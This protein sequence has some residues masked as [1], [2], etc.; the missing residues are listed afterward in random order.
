MERV[1]FHWTA[2]SNKASATDKEHYHILI[3]GDG[4]LIRG[5]PAID[6]NVSPV[7]PGYAAHTRGLNS[8]SIGVS[9]CGMAGATESPFNAGRTP[10]TRI[11]WEIL[12]TVLA[13][14]CRRYSIPVTRGTVLSHAE[15]Q[16]TLGVAQRGKW[17]ITR[18]PWD[19]GVR[20]AL[21]VGNLMRAA[22]L[23]KL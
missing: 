4:K 19:E 17:D 1:V 22:T 20:G 2:G 10:I 13:D 14:L 9:L 7:K 21:V 23:E 16:P 3:E 15:V 8:G 5:D 18:L 12:S 11:Q 6:K